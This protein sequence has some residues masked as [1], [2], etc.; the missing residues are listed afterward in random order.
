MNDLACVRFLFG[1]LLAYKKEVKFMVVG[2]LLHHLLLYDPEHRHP[3]DSHNWIKVG[4]KKLLHGC[5]E[6]IRNEME[7]LLHDSSS[8]VLLA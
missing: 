4:V 2:L 8:L 1:I 3:G 7:V 6:P 5:K